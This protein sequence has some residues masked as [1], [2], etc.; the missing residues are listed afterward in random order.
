MTSEYEK[1]K[2]QL[3]SAEDLACQFPEG[4]FERDSW[5][6]IAEGYRALLR[7]TSDWSG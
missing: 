7:R 2:A 4:S 6:K 5:L 1:H 3:K